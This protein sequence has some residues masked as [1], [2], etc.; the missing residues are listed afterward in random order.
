MGWLIASV[1]SPTPLMLGV[2]VTVVASSLVF[3]AA[4][5]PKEWAVSGAGRHDNITV[6]RLYTGC[7]VCVMYS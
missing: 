5:W 4:C 1:Y 2:M 3:V 7:V 6:V